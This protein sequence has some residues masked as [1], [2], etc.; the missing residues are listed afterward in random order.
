[1]HLLPAGQAGVLRNV[2]FPQHPPLDRKTVH[3]L[4]FLRRFEDLHPIFWV[5]QGVPLWTLLR[6]QQLSRIIL[7]GSVLLLLER[8]PEICPV[9]HEPPRP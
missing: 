4:L 6:F 2:L 1:M 7:L 3:R 8:D 5:V 9:F